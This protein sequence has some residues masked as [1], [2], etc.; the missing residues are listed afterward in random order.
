M[1]QEQVPSSYLDAIADGEKTET[2]TD[3]SEDE[4]RD[5]D[6]EFLNKLVTRTLTDEDPVVVPI[7]SDNCSTYGSTQ[8]IEDADWEMLTTEE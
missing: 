5:F 6:K 1:E 3:T 2:E 7:F 8:W 4:D